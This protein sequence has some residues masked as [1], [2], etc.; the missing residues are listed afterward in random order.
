MFSARQ[1]FTQASRRSF[2]AS[3]RQVCLE[4]LDY[5]YR[6]AANAYVCFL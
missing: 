4:Y 3:A 1:I 2:S 6:K 5:I